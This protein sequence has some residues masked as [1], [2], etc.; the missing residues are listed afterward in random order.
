MVKGQRTQAQLFG[1]RLPGLCCKDVG[2]TECAP[3]T[4]MPLLVL[5]GLQQHCQASKVAC[6]PQKKRLA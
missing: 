4:L 6:Q 5:A 2:C 3:D 1:L